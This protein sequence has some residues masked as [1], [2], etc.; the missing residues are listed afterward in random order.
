LVT[1]CPRAGARAAL[2]AKVTE[3]MTADMPAPLDAA[4]SAALELARDKQAV[5]VGPGLGVDSDGAA[6][7][8]RLAKE[9]PQPALL[10]ADALS[11]FTGCLPQLQAAA[12]PRV[13]TPHPGEAGRLLG[14]TSQEVQLHRYAAA[15]RL[16]ADSGCVVVLKGARTLIASPDGGLRVC[17]L[18]VPALA[19]A[20]TGD[21]LSGTIGAL[22]AE[23]P[24]PDAAAAG[25]Y[26]HALA[27]SLAAR[28]DRG[29]LAHEVAD[30]LPL[31]LAH[32]RGH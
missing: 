23:L 27:G 28:T 30:A 29:L 17:P 3:L 7:A 2:D 4:V 19:V 6:L 16:A 18:D 31:A 26:L 12:G 20:G 8:R 1:L 32:C 24:A 9:L 15:K 5:V 14:S 13:L 21:V 10:D 25:V 22:L 11:A